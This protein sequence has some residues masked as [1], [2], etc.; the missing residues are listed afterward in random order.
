MPQAAGASID[1]LCRLAAIH[2]ADLNDSNKR[3]Q[4]V[5]AYQVW[6]QAVKLTGDKLLGLHL[7]ESTNPTIL[8]LVGHL[9]QS[10]PD[11]KEAF[12]N[13]TR[14]SKTAT[15]M[16][17]YSI[18]KDQDEII[19]RFEPATV[20][21]KQS[22]DSARQAV[23]Q[24]MAGT[25]NVFYL[26]S[27]SKISPLRTTFRHRRPGPIGEYER[28]F[29]S[30]LQFNAGANQL[31]FAERQLERKI[32]SYDLSLYESFERMLDEKSNR[33]AASESFTRKLTNVV[34]T[35]FKGQVPS[36][37]VLASHAGL[38]T[39]T[40]QR[41]LESEG[42]TFRK[43]TGEIKAELARQMLSRP[44]S[45]VDYVANVLG[46]SEASAFRRAFKSWTTMSPRKQRKA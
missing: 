4:F 38:T 15:D 32:M 40:L 1:E 19:L 34:L 22:P 8:G 3:L 5:P 29:R 9:M 2:V 18:H 7:G 42:S 24:A 30:A 27:G 33:Q 6:E 10:S 13:V 44:G 21:V 35:V 23:E 37:Q 26:L 11:L 43:M 31:I 28:V 25:L 41:K 14:Y 39:R 45:K 20:W 46:Y 17:Q 12:R 16:F 36:I